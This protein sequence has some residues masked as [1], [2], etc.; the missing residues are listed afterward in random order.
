MMNARGGDAAAS[1]LAQRAQRLTLSRGRSLDWREGPLVMGIINVTPD[2]FSDG[3]VNF[4]P[5]TALDAALRME[6]EGAAIVD[7]GGEST[8]PGAEPVSASAEMDRVVPVIEAIR[9]RSSVP[10]SVD[11]SKAEVAAA[12]LAAGADLVNDVTALRGDSAMADVVREH[13]AGVIL[14]HMRGEPRSMQLNIEFENLIGEI[15]AELRGFRDAAIARGIDPAKILVDPG[16]GFGKT[17]DHNLEILA[18]A[19]ELAPIA[20]LVIAASRKAFI[21]DLTGRPAGAARMAGSLATVAA[22][23]DCGAAIVR[24]HDVAES[25]DFLKVHAA[26]R[27]LAR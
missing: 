19:R 12:A 15:A 5:A 14:M 21:G 11:T 25:A 10:I 13:A 2:S 16:I 6:R 4:E 22:A 20:P 23:A 8:R 27:S 24:V 9:R 26:I 1:A 7:V 18:R 17:F 3:G